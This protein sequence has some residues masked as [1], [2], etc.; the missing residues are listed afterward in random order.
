M[1]FFDSVSYLRTKCGK[2]WMLWWSR[3]RVRL[4][5]D[6]LLWDLRI[7]NAGYK[8]TDNDMSMSWTPAPVTY[9]YF[10]VST[11]CGISVEWLPGTGFD[12]IWR[13]LLVGLF[14]RRVLLSLISKEKFKWFFFII[15][16]IS[17]AAKRLL[18]SRRYEWSAT[19]TTQHQ[20]RFLELR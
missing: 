7:D 6:D 16:N 9:S 1:E 4:G 2:E 20:R 5:H 19:T 17:P 13:N 3:R 12:L 11:S 15:D 18:F 10:I 14:C 8:R